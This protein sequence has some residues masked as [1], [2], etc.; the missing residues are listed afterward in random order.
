MVLDTESTNL[1]EIRK[2]Q[3]HIFWTGIVLTVYTVKYFR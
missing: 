2:E 3:R 1:E